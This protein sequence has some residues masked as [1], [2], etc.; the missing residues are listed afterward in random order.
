MVQ[1]SSVNA[2][3]VTD[4]NGDGFP[5]LVMGGNE[6]GF[7]PQFSRL[8]GS[9]GNAMINNGKGNFSFMHNVNFGLRLCGQVLLSSLTCWLS[10]DIRELGIPGSPYFYSVSTKDDVSRQE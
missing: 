7:L 10:A 4:V 5:D 9:F 3:Q 8:N 2:I 1:L 6:F